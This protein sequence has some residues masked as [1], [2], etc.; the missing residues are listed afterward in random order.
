MILVRVNIPA[1]TNNTIPIVPV[2]VPVKYKVAKRAE[3]IT[4]IILSAVLMFFFVFEN[5]SC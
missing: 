5:F 3:I 1:N 4:L 2:T